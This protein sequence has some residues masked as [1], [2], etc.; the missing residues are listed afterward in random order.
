MPSGSLPAAPHRRLRR[1]GTP[2]LRRRR[3]SA[4]EKKAAPAA[5]PAAEGAPATAGSAAK[6]GKEGSSSGRNAPE[7]LIAQLEGKIYDAVVVEDY[8]AAAGARDELMDCLDLEDEGKVLQANAALYDAFSKKD[9]KQMEALWLQAPYVECI[10]PLEKRNSGHSAVIQSWKRLF[11]AATARKSTISAEDVR[12]TV[13]GATAI[14]ACSERVKS[15]G[16][17]LPTRSMMATNIFRK[18]GER[19]LLIH[20][21]VSPIATNMRQADGAGSNMT[22]MLGDLDGDSAQGALDLESIARLLGGSMASARIVIQQGNNR[23]YNNEDDGDDDDDDDEIVKQSGMSGTGKAGR[24]GKAYK[25]HVGEI[26]EMANLDPA[27]YDS[28]EDS[29]EGMYAESD[30]EDGMEVARETVRALRQLHA[31]GLITPQAKVRLLAE[32]VKSDGGSMP[33]R[34]YELLLHS[35]EDSE[36]EEAWA[37]FAALIACEAKRLEEGTLRKKDPPDGGNKGPHKGFKGPKHGG[38]FQK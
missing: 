36:R 37:D 24:K 2:L 14:V 32:V 35:V 28:D 5:T 38:P 18:V 3:R 1:Q 16:M 6:A 8:A 9:L 20:R 19:W 13:R 12:V 22:G 21:H 4:A 17:T 23:A 29:D 33:E 26:L 25:K 31:E 15:K 27:D 30:D 7:E 34:A 11:E 10:H